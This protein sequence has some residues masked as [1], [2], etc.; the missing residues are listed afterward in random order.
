MGIKILHK[1]LYIFSFTISSTIL[2]RCEVNSR[3][4]PDVIEHE[5]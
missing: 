3:F 4:P 5:D 2:E 1:I